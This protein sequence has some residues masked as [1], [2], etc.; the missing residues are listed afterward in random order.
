MATLEQTGKDTFELS[1]RQPGI[2]ADNTANPAGNTKKRRGQAATIFACCDDHCDIYVN[3]EKLL[4]ADI[5]PVAMTDFALAKGDIIT[6]KCTNDWG[7]MGLPA[8]S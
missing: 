5:S 2:T 8:P 4:H 7:G 3:G 1:G 6:V